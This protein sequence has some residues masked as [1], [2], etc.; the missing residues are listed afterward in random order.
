MCREEEP[1]DSW[2][3]DRDKQDT[4]L[5][6]KHCEVLSQESSPIAV[7]DLCAEPG[8]HPMSS[9]WSGASGEHYVFANAEST[10]SSTMRRLG[11][12]AVVE[13]S[14]RIRRPNGQ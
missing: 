8:L 11:E 5:L 1:V 13:K 6:M 9:F 4:W 3:C 2:R 12:D 14:A 7:L 10:A